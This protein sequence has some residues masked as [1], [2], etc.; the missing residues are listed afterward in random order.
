MNMI[1]DMVWMIFICGLLFNLILLMC[2]VILMCR[3]V[4]G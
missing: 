2:V 3:F 1:G 4:V